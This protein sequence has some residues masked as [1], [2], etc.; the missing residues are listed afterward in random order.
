MSSR[1]D[2]SAAGSDLV[3]V[4]RW[5]VPVTSPFVS[6]SGFDVRQ[7]LLEP[8]DARVRDLGVP[9]AQRP[10]LGQPCEAFQPV[11][12]N[13]GAPQAQRLELGQPSEVFQPEVRNVGVVEVQ[14]LQ[15][16]QPFEVY[17]PGV[18]ELRA[19]QMQ[20]LKLVS[21][22]GVPARRP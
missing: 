5:T 18:R 2:G 15:P 10:E 8:L 1:G 7:R 3:T 22:R 14:P 11:V 12:G 4:L 19:P 21:R 16:A 9:Q 6:A 20:R 17:Q 13:V